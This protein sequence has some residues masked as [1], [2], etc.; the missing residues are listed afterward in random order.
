[1]KVIS[2]WQPYASLIVQGIKRVETRR[3]TPPDSLLGQR[4]GIASTKGWLPG[5]KDAIQS[6]DLKWFSQLLDLPQPEDLPRGVLLGTVVLDYWEE[7][8]GHV[9]NNTPEKEKAFGWWVPGSYAWHLRDPIEWENPVPV[10]GK[11]GFFNYE[12]CEE[13]CG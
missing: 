9:I 3:W 7:M 4:I 11:Q 2:I 13:G 8:D 10:Q 6:H 1:M 12:G 5:Q